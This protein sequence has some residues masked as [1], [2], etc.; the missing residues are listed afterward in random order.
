MKSGA[1]LPKSQVLKSR[2][3][4]GRI[5][6][7]GKWHRGELF[8]LIIAPNGMLKKESTESHPKFAVLVN[9]KC[10]RAVKRNR[11]KRLS[12][13]YFRLNV[14]LFQSY[15]AV[16][17]AFDRTIEDESALKKEMIELTH[18]VTCNAGNCR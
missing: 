13:E 3:D 5:F 4:I 9:K 6:K 16:I 7:Q 12:R 15:D 17:F 10:G 14:A 1:K 2:A 18:K 8:N 11:L